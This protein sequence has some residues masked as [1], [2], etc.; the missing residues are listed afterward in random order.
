VLQSVVSYAGKFAALLMALFG[1]LSSTI[2]RTVNCNYPSLV[3][4]DRLSESLIGHCSEIL[5]TP[6]LVI[7]K[8]DFPNKSDMPVIK[9]VM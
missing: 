5:D 2:R 6:M 4:T 8:S 3:V 1:S 9:A 7:K